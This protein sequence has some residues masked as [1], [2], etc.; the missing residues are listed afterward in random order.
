MLPNPKDSPPRRTEQLRCMSIA[1]F[2]IGQ[3]AF[4]KLAIASRNGAVGRTSMPEAAVNE[5][6]HTFAVKDKIRP[7]EQIAMSPPSSDPASPEDLY[8]SDFSSTIAFAAN[9]GHDCRALL[10]GVNVRHLAWEERPNP[11]RRSHN[12]R[13]HSASET[14]IRVNACPRSC[15]IRCACTGFSCPAHSSA[16]CVPGSNQKLPSCA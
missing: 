3:F 15:A 10:S 12:S 6:G 11:Y 1:F 7:T 8:R 14:A 9:R 16:F 2:I 4:P 5:Y 13:T